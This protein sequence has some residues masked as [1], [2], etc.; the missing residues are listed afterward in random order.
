M[1]ISFE[2]E[3]EGTVE[4]IRGIFLAYS[5]HAWKYPY[6]AQYCARWIYVM[7]MEKGNGQRDPKTQM[8]TWGHLNCMI[9]SHMPYD[10]QVKR[11]ISFKNQKKHYNKYCR[12]QN[13][14]VDYKKYL[15]KIKF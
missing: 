2:K 1:S 8:R 6:V 4:D 15:D 7:K 11:K 10:H 12:L 13:I 3:K 9:V 5:I 14:Y